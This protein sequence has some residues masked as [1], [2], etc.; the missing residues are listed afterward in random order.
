MTTKRAKRN[1][2]KKGN[3]TDSIYRLSMTNLFIFI[4]K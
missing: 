1:Y 3:E 2:I 4:P